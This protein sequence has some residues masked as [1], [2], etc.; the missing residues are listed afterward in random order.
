MGTAAKLTVSEVESLAPDA[1]S[2]KAA[3]G[4]VK[5]GKWPQLEYSEQALWGQCQGSG[6]N[7][8]VAMV[9]LSQ[10][11]IAF[12]CSCPSRK[13]PC[14]HGL[15]L[16]LNFVEHQDWFSAG[17]EPQTVADWRSKRA[18]SAEKKEQRSQEKLAKAQEAIAKAKEAAIQAA[19]EGK[20]A[21]VKAK[22]AT[23][24]KR[25]T[26][27]EEGVAELKLWLKDCLRNGLLNVLDQRF[28]DIERLKRRLVDA[29]APAL[30]T[31]LGAT[32]QCDCSSQEGRRDY[33]KQ[34][35]RLYLL[36]SAFEHR[37]SL[38]PEWQSEIARLVGIPTPKEEVLAATIIAQGG[39]DSA[40]E[41]LLVLADI[42][43]PVSNGTNHKYF[44]Y[45][46]ASHQFMAYMLFVPSNAQAA[47]ALTEQP[48]PVGAVVQ[49][50]VY[51]YPGVAQV[52]RVLLE[53]RKLLATTPT[54][55]KLWPNDP[56]A[57]DDEQGDLSDNLTMGFCEAD[58]QHLSAADQ[59]ELEAALTCDNPTGSYGDKLVAPA[60]TDP[61]LWRE[62]KGVPDLAAAV[63]AMSQY[64][65]QNPF[66][67]FYPVM[68][69]HANF[70]Q[71]GKPRSGT[72]FL[73]DNVGHARALSGRKE[74][75]HD[76]VVSCLAHTGGA[77]FSAMVLLNDVE[78]ILCGIACEGRYLPL[79]STDLKIF[80]EKLP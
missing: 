17:T 16:L 77:E 53:E 12:K 15:A 56:L 45:R 11:D 48:L 54:A 79:T 76:Q 14:K 65:A 22:S 51:S 43:Y 57:M 72:W 55:Q 4:L 39:Q 80:G 44:C 27:I 31:L 75:L 30:A 2:L 36:A 10:A 66:A 3:R 73:C 34:L 67:D 59:A 52:P 61:E 8:Y 49:A 33:L 18:A 5:Q 6:K 32:L 50:K 60:A 24:V 7:P 69:E 1:S 58:S 23:Q 46:V 37:E 42:P 78:T 74:P 19:T 40:P 9:D 26:A 70:A 71:Q 25:E 63:D 62:L 29:K 35:S 38:A 21:P 64:L 28:K 47:A 13:F 68:I 20:A 41:T